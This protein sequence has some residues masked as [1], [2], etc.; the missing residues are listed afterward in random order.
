MS[1]AD[2]MGVHSEIAIH[3]Q[4]SHMAAKNVAAR[5]LRQAKSC[6]GHALFATQ[7]C[8]GAQELGEQQEIG[9]SSWPIC[10]TI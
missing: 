9:C 7:A 4:S 5:I 6:Y 2:V 1:Y 10:A 8:P 3:P